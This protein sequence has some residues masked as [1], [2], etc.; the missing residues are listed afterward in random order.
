[1][2]PVVRDDRII[3]TTASRPACTPLRAVSS[4]NGDRSG[5]K[6]GV[7]R[8]GRH[9]RAEISTSTPTPTTTIGQNIGQ[10]NQGS[11]SRSICR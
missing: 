10:P 5:G 7:S 8:H 2:I 4:E 3:P 9:R 1:M 6:S 11:T